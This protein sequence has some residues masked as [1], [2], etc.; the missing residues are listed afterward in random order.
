MNWI[1]GIIR[2]I[3]PRDVDC[4]AAE[5]IGVRGLIDLII[6]AIQ[7]MWIQG[8]ISKSPNSNDFGGLT[9]Y[10]TNCVLLHIVTEPPQGLVD[11]LL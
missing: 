7:F 5:V 2:S 11:S 8:T 1:A 4:Q 10:I 6:P 3:S 9:V